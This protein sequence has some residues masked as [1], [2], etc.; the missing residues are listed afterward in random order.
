MYPL[1]L[2]STSYSAWHVVA[3]GV[4]CAAVLCVGYFAC[5][6]ACRVAAWLV[7]LVLRTVCKLLFCLLYVAVWLVQREFEAEV[8]VHL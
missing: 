7:R 3:V 5:V 4:A 6:L 2:S 8:I 1:M